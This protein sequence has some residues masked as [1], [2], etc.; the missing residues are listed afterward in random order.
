LQRVR[1]N[2][3]LE[4]AGRAGRWLENALLVILFAALMLLATSQIV[5][6]DV[7]STALLWSD[8]AVRL[9][10]L[11]LAVVGAVAASR[12][13]KHIAIDLA[14]RLLPARLERPVGLAVALFTAVVTGSLAWFS[15]RFVSDS[16]EFGDTLLGN[17]P[18]WILQLILPI[19]FA[20]ISYRYCLRFLRLCRGAP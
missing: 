14:G 8:G 20:L 19:G 17:W 12:D 10:V 1:L 18:A 15:W 6:R 2:R 13:H 11:W 7:F 4:L 16:R 3:L 5:L 9:L